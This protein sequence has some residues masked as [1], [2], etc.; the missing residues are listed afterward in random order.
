MLRW[1]IVIE[2]RTDYSQLVDAIHLKHF[3]VS[4]NRNRT[5]LSSWTRIQK[6]ALPDS[7]NTYL[8]DPSLF[9]AIETSGDCSSA[10]YLDIANMSHNITLTDWLSK[11]FPIWTIEISE[12]DN[13]TSQS[14][15]K[16]LPHLDLS[17]NKLLRPRQA[18]MPM[19]FKWAVFIAHSFVAGCFWYAYTLFRSSRLSPPNI[20]SPHTMHAEGAPFLVKPLW[21]YGTWLFLA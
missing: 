10:F 14:I 12:L 20:Q 17:E 19:E 4:K 2:E 8:P 7:L 21:E 6:S 3:A 16:Q 15:R 5:R 13:E 1:S 11:L 18:T 9:E